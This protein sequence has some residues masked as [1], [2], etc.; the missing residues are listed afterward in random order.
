MG[1]AVAL[2][3]LK[4]ALASGSW[5]SLGFGPRQLR[6]GFRAADCPLDSGM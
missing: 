1:F 2:M 6:L 4:R 3:L 5:F